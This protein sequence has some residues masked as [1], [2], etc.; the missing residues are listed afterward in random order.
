MMS[1]LVMD[2]LEAYS[3]SDLWMVS[4]SLPASFFVN[5]RDVIMVLTVA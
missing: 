2:V 1:H 3:L 4:E 5:P